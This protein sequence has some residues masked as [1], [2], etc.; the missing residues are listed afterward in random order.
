MGKRPFKLRVRIPQYEYPPKRWRQKI[1]ER[2]LQALSTEHIDYLKTDNLELRI[3]L[4]MNKGAI[5]I[6]DIDNRLKDMMDALQGRMGGKKKEHK[7]KQIIPND[8]KIYRVMIE[9]KKPP[10][11]NLEGGYLEIRKYKETANKSLQR[12]AYSHR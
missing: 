1:H 2:V 9:K 6:H 10:K 11:R 4:Y 5:D 12:M 7:F 8:R 3:V